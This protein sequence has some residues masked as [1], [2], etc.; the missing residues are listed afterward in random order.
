MY[1]N[2]IIIFIVIVGFGCG[3][4]VDISNPDVP[5]KGN[6]IYTSTVKYY[7][8]PGGTVE[9]EKSF[10]GYLSLTTG[11]SNGNIEIQPEY[12][13]DWTLF[14]DNIT[15]VLGDT[16]LMQ[17]PDQMIS[18]SGENYSVIGME[19]YKNEGEIYHVLQTS[20][21]IFIHYN[22]FLPSTSAEYKYTEGVI[23]G[24]WFR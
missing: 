22:S 12:G 7:K 11:A 24:R 15:S 3:N 23:K 21:S 18:I 17:I 1:K 4:E 20:D 2:I 8:I 9:A 10:Q 19:V 5:E 16:T 14:V 13:T 6:Y